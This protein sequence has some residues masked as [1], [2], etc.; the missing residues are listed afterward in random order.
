MNNETTDFVQN[1]ILRIGR[2]LTV[3]FVHTTSPHTNEYTIMSAA[4]QLL[5][6]LHAYIVPMRSEQGPVTETQ[7]RLSR[8]ILEQA[9][10]RAAAEREAAHGLT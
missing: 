10:D 4:A 3:G 9:L 1:D 7:R 8:E 5:E 6:H 2:L